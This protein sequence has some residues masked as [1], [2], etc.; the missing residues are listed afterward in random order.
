MTMELENSSDL[1]ALWPS[2]NPD[3]MQHSPVCGDAGVDKPAA[4]P[5]LEKH[6][7]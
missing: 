2:W 4:L 6:C 7:T 5:V 3:M 1:G